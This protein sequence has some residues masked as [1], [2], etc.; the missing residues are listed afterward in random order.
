MFRGTTPT[1]YFHITNE[2]INFNDIKEAWITLK[3]KTVEYN[4]K[5]SKGRVLTN[6][7]N[8]LLFVRLTQEETLSLNEDNKAFVQLRL[9]LNS[10]VFDRALASEI[11]QIDVKDILKEGVIDL[12]PPEPPEP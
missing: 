7:S 11:N 8:K 12:E 1:I 6:L 3:N 4:F 2:D 5:L 9:L 10:N